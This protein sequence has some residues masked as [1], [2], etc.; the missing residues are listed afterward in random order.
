MFAD[1]EPSAAEGV[2]VPPPSVPAVAEGVPAPAAAPA[3]PTPVSAPAA[4]AEEDQVPMKDEP[5]APAEAVPA[6]AA[7]ETVAAAPMEAEVPMEV[8][9]E[10]PM[11]PME[12][13]EPM[14]PAVAFHKGEV[15]AIACPP[16]EAFWLGI[17]RADILE[18]DAATRAKLEEQERTQEAPGTAAP[19]PS[20]IGCGGVDISDT[21]VWVPIR[22]LERVASYENGDDLYQ[23]GRDERVKRSTVLGVAHVAPAAA[24]ALVGARGDQQYVVTMAE[25]HRLIRLIA[26]GDDG[27]REDADS[28]DVVDGARVLAIVSRATVKESAFFLVKWAGFE[29][30][31]MTWEPMNLLA[32]C[33]PD[34]VAH[35]D[36]APYKLAIQFPEPQPQVIPDHPLAA[37][38]TLLLPGAAPTPDMLAAAAASPVPAGP[39]AA[40][41]APGAK[42]PRGRQGGRTSTRGRGAA[43]ARARAADRSPSPLA[44]APGAP[45]PAPFFGTPATLADP[46]AG[47]VSLGSL[48]HLHGAATVPGTAAAPPPPPPPLPQ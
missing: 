20:G 3:V 38:G 10:T 21:R 48:P 7:A 9:M 19:T 26:N 41:A 17:A 46:S 11:E 45:L 30:A 1:S 24:D 15:V 31:A 28:G 27:A 8:P 37:D 23:Q 47:P 42:T 35:F 13:M 36:E 18:I 44:A 2:P 4:L 22:W 34:L 25:R 5:P 39:A 16:P 43:A 12:A 6:A 14:E 29:N 40:A 33:C 32:E